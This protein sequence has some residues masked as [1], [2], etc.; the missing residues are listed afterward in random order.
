MRVIILLLLISSSLYAQTTELI[1]NAMKS[2]VNLYA[3]GNHKHDHSL[4]SGI[5][6]SS[7]GYLITNA[8]V[9]SGYGNIIVTLEDKN[10][11]KAKLIGIDNDSDIAVLKIDAKNLN[12]LTVSYRPLTIGQHVYAIGNPFGFTHSVTS[13]IISALGRRVG[14]LKY[15]NFIQIDAPINPGNSGGALVDEQGKLIGINSAIFSKTGANNGVGFAIPSSI[16]DPI[17]KQIMDHGSVNR[18]LLGVYVQE[19]NPRIADAMK[20]PTLAGVLVTNIV[21][22]SNAAA[23]G[24]QPFDIITHINKQQI[25]SFT[26]LQSTIATIRIDNK[27][28]V[29]IIR[30][31]KKLNLSGTQKHTN[32]KHYDNLLSGVKLEPKQYWDEEENLVS[33]LEV[34]AINEDSKAWMAD[35]RIK[36]IITTIN[37]Q[38]CRNLLELARIYQKKPAKMLMLV[39]RMSLNH[40]LILQ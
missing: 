22:N 37:N 3:F 33:G 7:K 10:Y 5:I 9:V 38:P 28:D 8:H 14:L 20:I 26:D 24:L 23:L 17:I 31:G 13:G 32:S 11:Y 6:I 15:E 18:G 35:L 4:G 1:N 36:D 40:V 12:P 21:P 34:T 39:K 25:D 2:V 16:F 19:L 30:N 27:I 29:T